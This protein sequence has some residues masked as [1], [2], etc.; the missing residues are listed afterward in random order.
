MHEEFAVQHEKKF[1]ALFGLNSYGCCE[2]LHNKLDL[3]IRNIPNL[4]RFSISPW[5]DV[6]KCAEKLQNKYI[7]S[8]KPNPAMLASETFNPEA[9]RRS[10]TEFCEKTKGCV[11][12]I[13]MK[14]T[15]TL[16]N[17]PHRLSEW[18]RITKEVVA[19]FHG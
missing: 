15:H 2:P 4:R 5:A 16:R 11:T 14:D 8:Y 3:L 12:E 10:I 6:E 9:V 17:E 7:Y 1:L 18:V 19:E 13:V